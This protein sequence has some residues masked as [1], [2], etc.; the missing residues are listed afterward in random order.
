MVQ[1]TVTGF[2]SS[3]MQTSNVKFVQIRDNTNAV[4]AGYLRTAD[5]N[6]GIVK[7]IFISVNSND[8]S[9]S[10][11]HESSVTRA[12]SKGKSRSFFGVYG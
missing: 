4:V 8:K 9:I 7:R 12:D 1:V 2:D 5:V 6:E 10:Q 3:S 11:K